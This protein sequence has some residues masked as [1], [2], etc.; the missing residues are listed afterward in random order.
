MLNWSNVVPEG[1]AAYYEWHNRE[2]M[3]GVVQIPGFLRGRRHIVIDGDRDFF[4]LYEAEDLSVLKGVPYRTKI[5][6]PSS[7]TRSTTKYIKDAIR[8]L[9]LVRKSL[10][11]GQGAFLLTLRFDVLPENEGRL[12]AFL[13]E[14]A[15]PAIVAMPG[16]ISAHFCTSDMTASTYVSEERKGR[17]TDVPNWIII[18]EGI[19]LAAV[20]DAGDAVLS[21]K[22]LVRHNAKGP[23]VRGTYV[24]EINVAKSDVASIGEG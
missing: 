7:L 18:V 17:P 14:E 10:G 8:G 9:A 3:V 1:K 23:V 24:Q 11:V 19:S 12:A 15:L 13:A 6:N 2:H 21:D 4:N 16:V 5:N 20:Q 22:M